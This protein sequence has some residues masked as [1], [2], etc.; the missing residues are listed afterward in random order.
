MTVSEMPE[1]LLRVLSGSIHLTIHRLYPTSIRE[2]CAGFFALCIKH[3]EDNKNCFFFLLALSRSASSNMYPSNKP[4]GIPREARGGAVNRSGLRA[5]FLNMKDKS[6]GGSII[7][8][9]WILTAAHCVREVNPSE[10]S[11]YAGSKVVKN[12]TQVLLVSA[13]KIHPDYSP[14]TNVNNIALLH[15]SIP[16]NMSDT[17]VG[18]IDLPPFS[19][20]A[21]SDSKWPPAGINVSGKGSL[22]VQWQASLFS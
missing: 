13:I 21:L 11:I 4:A 1:V 12:S 5:V 8:P 22:R 9:S 2:K 19:F 17:G 20:T 14:N 10:I 3:R 7:T 16:L 6:C 18:I 15:L